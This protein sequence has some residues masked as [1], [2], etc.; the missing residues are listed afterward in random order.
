MSELSLAKTGARSYHI[1]SL[2][3]DLKN[4][5]DVVEIAVAPTPE[6]EVVHPGAGDQSLRFAGSDTVRSAIDRFDCPAVGIDNR[7]LIVAGFGPRML[8]LHLRFR[9][10]RCAPAGDVKVI[11]MNVR[12]GGAQAR[13]ERQC[14]VQLV[15]HVQKNVLVDAA[16]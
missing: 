14:L 2:A 6:I 4:C 11:C 15:S 16:I 5:V 12:A 3:I 8:V 9:S 10:N 7:Y 13:T 1:D